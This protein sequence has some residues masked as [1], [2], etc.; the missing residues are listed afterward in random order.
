VQRCIDACGSS[1]QVVNCLLEES[2]P[3]SVASLD[4]TLATITP[5]AAPTPPASSSSSTPKEVISNVFDGDEFD[6]ASVVEP[7]RIWQGK[8]R[9]AKKYSADS[10]DSV[11]VTRQLKL[12]ASFDEY[13][14]D[15]DD[16][17]DEDGGG[18]FGVG[19][20]NNSEIENPFTQKKDE[21]AE[22][23]AYN[24]SLKAKEVSTMR[25][26]VASTWPV[27][28]TMRLGVAYYCVLCV[29]C[30]PTWPVHSLHASLRYRRPR[31][32]TGKA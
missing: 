20:D 26:G 9:Q 5:A 19:G 18:R 4:R 29:Y 22:A 25:L 23:L 32:R 16:Q 10:T 30:A 8:K 31:T 24:K 3:P 14:D 6:T 17:W 28:R 15:Y 2:L 1:E 12:L 7:S 27:L 21:V 13:D 11:M